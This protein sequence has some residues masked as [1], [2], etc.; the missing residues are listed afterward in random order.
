MSALTKRE[1]IQD[2][3]NE[4]RKGPWTHEEDNI[5]IHY[6]ACHDEGHWNLLARCS[7]L[8]RTGKSCRLRWL[9]YLK[10]DV[11]R[12]RLSHEEQL[13]IL[14]L[15]SKWGNRWSRIAQHFPGRTDNDIKNYWRTRVQKH[16]RQLNVDANS[17]RFR[18]AIRCIWM[19]TLLQKMESCSSIIPLEST[20][21]PSNQASQAS[22]PES[23]STIEQNTLNNS[24]CFENSHSED[25]SLSISSDPMEL[26]QVLEISEFSTSPHAFGNIF[27][28]PSIMDDYTERNLDMEALNLTSISV[29][30]FN[31]PFHDCSSM[32]ESNWVDVV[33]SLWNIDELRHVSQLQGAKV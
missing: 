13:L 25:C 19:P 23:H 18:D 27:Y 15:H 32:T 6:I 2:E 11:K 29:P 4:L 12:G 20:P 26:N 7:G 3:D 17:S 22:S 10:P 14:E 21:T 1:C 33:D 31:Y 28:N 16:A 24:H 8:K 30:D 9:N 5:L